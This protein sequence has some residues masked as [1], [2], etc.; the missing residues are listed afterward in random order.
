MKRFAAHDFEDLLQVGASL[1]QTFF[2]SAQY[3]FLFLCAVLAV[4]NT[5][6]RWF[7]RWRG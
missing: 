1:H 5:G 7:I 2:V 3:M 4:R 6:V